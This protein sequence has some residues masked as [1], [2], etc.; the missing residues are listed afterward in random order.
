MKRVTAAYVRV[1]SDGQ[2][3][4]SQRSAIRRAAA[5]RG[6][7]VARWYAETAS[8]TDTG[9]RLELERV[10]LAAKRG[11]LARLYVFALDRLTRRGIPEMFRL[12]HELARHGCLVISLND[13]FD[14]EGPAGELLLAVAAWGAKQE[15]RR[16]GERMRAARARVEAAGGAWGRPRRMTAELAARVWALRAKGKSVRQIAVALKIPRATVHDELRTASGKPPQKSTRPSP[17]KTPQKRG[18]KESRAGAV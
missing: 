16:L 3:D 18:A 6:H 1:S 10:R 15:A 13:P 8:A 7:D 5:A 4:R 9:P 17:P 2:S 12:V 14:F 11:E